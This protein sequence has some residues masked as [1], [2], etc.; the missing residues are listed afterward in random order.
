MCSEGCIPNVI[1]YTALIDGHCKAGEI[2]KA[3]Q[4]YARMQGNVEIS[5]VD[6]YFRIDDGNSKEPN[7]FTYGALVDGLCKAHKVKEARNLLDAISVEGCEPNHIVYDAL[8]DGFCKARKLD[9]AQEVFAKMSEHGYSPH[10]YTYS[11]LI[12]RL[13]KGKRL[14]LALK[15]LS[16]MLENSCAPNVVIYTEMIDGL[17]KVG[18]TDEAYK[19]MLM[20][21]EKGC[22][23]NVVTYTGMIDGFGKVGLNREFII[24][25]G[26]LD[27]I[28][29]NDSVPIVP[30]YRILIDSFIKAGRLESALELHEEIPSFFPLKAASKNMHTSLIESLSR[31]GKVVKAFEL[32]TDMVRM[33]GVAE[34]STFVHLIKGLININKWEEALQLSDSICQMIMT[35][36][37][38]T[39][40]AHMKFLGGDRLI[41]IA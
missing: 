3:C 1:T 2:E 7:V 33:G 12:D 29:E 37:V 18:R 16:K 34:L 4:I 25:L 15:V 22:Y 40:D 41:A 21:E 27:E 26:L 19:L 20:M 24:S 13:F 35:T 30:V 23:P 28:S 39:L 10:V 9:D 36:L 14:D 8:I 11:S 31:A 17:C 38:E 5:D 32:Y 6:M